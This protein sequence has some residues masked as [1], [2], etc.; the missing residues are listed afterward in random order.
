MRPPK[1]SPHLLACRHVV[2]GFADVVVG[3]SGGPDSLALTAALRAEAV[4]VEAVVVD[5]QLQPGS[6]EIA[7]RAAA[8]ARRLGA[9]ARVEKVNVAR[10]SLE[11]EARAVRYEALLRIAGD[12]PVLV[13]HTLEDQA[14]TLLLA[15]LRGNPGGMAAVSGQIH[16]PFLT[17][18]R[19][20][21]VGACEEM[22]L[23]YWEDPHNQDQGFRRVAVRQ[24]VMPLLGELIGGDALGPLAQAA[25]RIAAD[26]A[27]LDELAGP[28]T[29]DCAE[30]GAQPEPLRR[31]RI[32]AWLRSEGLGVTGAVVTGVDKLV[33]DWHG[34]G[35][36]AAGRRLDVW[37]IGGKLTVIPQEH[38]SRGNGHA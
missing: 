12:R 21:T 11:A 26:N 38:R 35:G 3:L 14:E 5:H 30:L 17:L 13:A 32:A 34:Q 16:R 10:G 4:A 15:A 37:R 20:D 31:R 25:D 7:Q 19:V 22:G 6:A 27:L 33:S 24:Q 29:T 28:P 2:R 1:H 36:V 23:E 9:E 18:R 8:Q